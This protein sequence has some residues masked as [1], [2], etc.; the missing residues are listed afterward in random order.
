MSLK[1]LKFE[2]VAR[3][4]DFSSTRN[5]LGKGGFGKVYRAAIG[6]EQV[7]VKLIEFDGLSEFP[8]ALEV[9]CRIADGKAPTQPNLLHLKALARSAPQPEPSL[10]ARRGANP[11]AQKCER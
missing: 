1:I 5:E 3:A 7:A 8:R 11:T 6:S 4:A 10:P 9:A 2:D